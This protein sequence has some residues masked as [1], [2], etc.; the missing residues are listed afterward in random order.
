[1]VACQIDVIKHML[2]R[3]ILSD[4]HGKW[5]YSL[6]EFDLVYESLKCTKG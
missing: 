5:A 3:P 6:I 2:H 1:M 4:R